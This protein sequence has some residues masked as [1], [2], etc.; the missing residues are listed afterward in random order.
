[1]AR[2]KQ[3]LKVSVQRAGDWPG[4]PGKSQV[5]TW[6][7]AAASNRGGQITV[8]FVDS[9]E[10]CRLNRDYRARDYATNVLSFP[11][12]QQPLLSGDLVLCVPVVAR[13]ATAQ[14]KSLEEH[15][16][17]LIVHGVLHLQGHDHEA[18]EMK[19]REME[20]HER[21]VLAALGYPDPYRDEE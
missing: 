4:L 7:R 3:R 15:C 11:Y 8:R 5:R 10:G 20:D 13:E 19:A 1:M 16:A 14:G 21:R 9:A 6:A 17:H 12:Q 2:D 18:G